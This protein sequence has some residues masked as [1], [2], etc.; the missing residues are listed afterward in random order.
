MLGSHSPILIS[1]DEEEEIYSHDNILAPDVDIQDSGLE[2]L[3]SHNDIVSSNKNEKET[4]PQ[5]NIFEELT[6]NLCVP[7]SNQT[8][9]KKSV[10]SNF[11]DIS[12]TSIVKSDL[13]ESKL[14][15]GVGQGSKQK[16][17]IF[18]SHN[19]NSDEQS[20]N[21]KLKQPEENH[22]KDM[23]G[24]ANKCFDISSNFNEP[25]LV[26]KT[27]PRPSTST[28]MQRSSTLR[29][30]KIEQELSTKSKP[31]RLPNL[32]SKPFTI[33]NFHKSI[34]D[35]KV[36]WFENHME[37]V[38][39][40]NCLKNVGTSFES[41]DEYCRTFW[42]LML[43]EAQGLVS[44]EWDEK[45]NSSIIYTVT[46]IDVPKTIVTNFRMKCEYKSKGKYVCCPAEEDL[47]LLKF[48]NESQSVKVFGI[49][50]KVVINYS[51]E[52]NLRISTCIL[53]V[54]LGELTN[55]KT[56]KYVSV[57]KI[58]SLTTVFRQFTG[59]IAFKNSL[60]ASDILKP[61]RMKTYN[62]KEKP[63]SKIKFK[64]LKKL[65]SAQLQA[66]ST[67]FHV[68]C[69]TEYVIPRIVLLQGPPGTGKSYTIK[70]II[71]HL[72]QVSIMITF[73]I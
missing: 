58:S 15:L 38:E 63:L 32:D 34:L 46:E 27:V 56:Y 53:K 19:K 7:E 26:K 31:L 23:S 25:L 71:T 4:F 62:C 68:V 70:T 59:L 49:V 21:D 37:P 42:N 30:E 61:F 14:I 11:N 44:K 60:L 2:P 48:T 43:C 17:D 39:T 55:S 3:K 35:W 64:R 66:V 50:E 45:S 33:S 52:N 69:Q 12:S 18:E 54:K 20:K 73:F 24:F 6:S 9:F 67:V 22:D 72:M 36:E 51:L 5:K 41:Y 16:S 57:T 13:K 8:K 65:N 28:S 29:R 40:C 10:T 47:V 1:D